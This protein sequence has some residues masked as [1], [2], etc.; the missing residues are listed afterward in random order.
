MCDIDMRPSLY[1]NL[2]VVGGNSL[3]QG[4]SFL[5]F[6]CQKNYQDILTNRCRSSSSRLHGPFEPRPESE[7]SPQHAVEAVVLE[8]VVGAALFFL[9]RRLHSRLSGLL[10]ADVDFQARV[11]RG[12]ENLRGKEMPLIWNS[13]ERNNSCH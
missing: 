8:P 4:K 3:S 9:D 7:A 13:F 2:I 12:R 5:V 1:S 11:R 10:P 6:M